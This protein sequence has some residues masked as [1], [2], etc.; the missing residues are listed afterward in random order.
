M[1]QVK[2]RKSIGTSGVADVKLLAKTVRISFADGDTY[3]LDSSTWDKKRTSGEY[4]VTMSK[5]GD[6]VIGLGAVPGTY[7]VRFKEFANRIDGIPQTKIQQGGERISRTGG[8]YIAPNKLVCHALLEIQSEDRF[9]GLNILAILPYG[10]EPEPGTNNCCIAVDGKRDLE[11]ID[12]FLRLTGFNLND[13]IPYA[14]NVLPWLEGVLQGKNI[15]FMVTINDQGFID[16]MAP[17]PAH[18]APK[19]KKA[20]K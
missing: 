5:Q 10:F 2:Q 4:R 12:S 15:A 18:L 16:T 3:E 8:K 1:V 14:Q 13:P 17:L 19:P 7:I 11:R 9:D 20:K 6:K